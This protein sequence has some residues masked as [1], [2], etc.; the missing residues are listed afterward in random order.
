[1]LF[2]NHGLSLKR[3]V[4]LEEGREKSCLNRKTKIQDAVLESIL[5]RFKTF[6]RYTTKSVHIQINLNVIFSL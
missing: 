5:E 1:M 4:F 2:S 3:E 6:P